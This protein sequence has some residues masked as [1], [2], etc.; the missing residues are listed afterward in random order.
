MFTN[1]LALMTAGDLAVQT[2]CREAI[3]GDGTERD[4]KAAE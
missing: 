4:S 1:S 3:Q 2:R